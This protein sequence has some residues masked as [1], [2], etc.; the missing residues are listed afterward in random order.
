M[1][2]ANKQ[3]K[4]YKHSGTT[5]NLAGNH[6]MGYS[7]ARELRRGLLQ[8]ITAVAFQMAFILLSQTLRRFLSDWTEIALISP[9]SR[10]IHWPTC[11]DIEAA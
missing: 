4:L 11:H 5:Q 8:C 1:H 7:F 2:G 3:C 10:L 9:L 6:V